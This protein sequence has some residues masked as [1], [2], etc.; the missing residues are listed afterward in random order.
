LHVEKL[1]PT[2]IWGLEF[3]EK[4]VFLMRNLYKLPKSL[5]TSGEGPAGRERLLR[6]YTEILLGKDRAWQQSN[7]QAPSH[8]DFILSQNYLYEEGSEE[9]LVPSPLLV[10]LRNFLEFIRPRGLR[11]KEFVS[12]FPSENERCWPVFV[13]YNGQFLS[14]SPVEEQ[15]VEVPA[16]EVE[17]GLKLFSSA[18]WKEKFPEII[19]KLKETPEGKFEILKKCLE[20]DPNWK[21][22]LLGDFHKD[23]QR[24]NHE[25]DLRSWRIWADNEVR[26]LMLRSSNPIGLWRAYQASI[27][28]RELPQIFFSELPESQDQVFFHTYIRKYV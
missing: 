8:E 4:L 20:D 23:V 19:E 9:I 11:A 14:L 5:P 1:Y 27:A 18:D 16:P 13:R 28:G 2:E 10:D 12:G 26:K 7:H 17:E 25:A 24:C 6:L 15:R 3:N 22:Y 21:P